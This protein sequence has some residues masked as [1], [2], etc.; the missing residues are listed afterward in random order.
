MTDSTRILAAAMITVVLV[1]MACT[2]TPARSDKPVMRREVPPERLDFSV[3]KTSRYLSPVGI[4]ADK[5][6]KTLYIAAATGGQVVIFD[7]TAGKV[8]DTVDVGQPLSGVAIS[9]DE[10]MLYVTTALA[11][12]KLCVIDLRSSEIIA[13]IPLGHS[14]ASPVITPDGQTAYVCNRF[15]S[16]V[17][18]VNLVTRRQA[19]T[20]RVGREPISADI[21]KDGSVLIVA[22]HLP[23][24]AANVDYVAAEVSIIDTASGQIVAA[25]ALPNGA[26]GLRRVKVSPDGRHAAVTHVV[27]RCHLPTTQL[28]RGWC[29]TNALSLIDVPKRSI[30][31]TILLDDVDRGAANP[32]AVA[33]TSDSRT[34]CVSH[35]GS[36]E[37][38]VIDVPAMIAKLEKAV[39]DD[40]ADQVQNDLAFLVG[41]R[42]RLKLAGNGPRCMTIVGTTAYV[43]EYFTDSLGVLDI[44]ANPLPAGRPVAR[45]VPLGRA[46]DMTPARR[47]EMYFNDAQLCFQTWMSC[48]SCHPD[49]RSGGLNW[50]LMSDG[51]GNSKNTKSLLLAYRTPPSMITGIRAKAEIAVRARIRFGQFAVRPEKDA[52][53]IDEYLK[54]LEPAPSPHLVNGRPSESALRGKEIFKTA[55]CSACHPAP[56]FTDLKRHN[57]GT[58][59]KQEVK[60]KFDTPT[61]VEAWRTA[62]YLHDG[63][64]E[65]V[66]GVLTVY[67]TG[68]RHG[69]TSK[70]TPGQLKDLAEYVLSL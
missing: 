67:N 62:P 61:L 54:S 12:G 22:S 68:D 2:R 20:L 4:V 30:V 28:E 46:G 17:G 23:D 10:S 39:N 9:P 38:S 1:H 47:G 32:W 19:R 27:S 21:S 5:A 15:D 35:A 60:Q 25:A 45:S 31:A 58:G 63:R 64:A 57:V 49:G 7:I 52:V 18:V 44:T 3:G 42:K 37:V 40:K 65:A 24:T 69:R 34:L 56:L 36:H 33:W 50:D 48:A 51:L 53:A 66:I 11:E 6:G 55:S 16:T 59:K 14:P 8:T 43:G 26:T 41:L 13:R 70:L 29:N